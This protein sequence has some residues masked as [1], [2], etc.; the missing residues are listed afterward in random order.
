MMQTFTDLAERANVLWQQR[1]SLAGSDYISLSQLQQHDRQLVQSVGLCQRYLKQDEADLPLWLIALLDNSAAELNKLLALPLALSAQ[2]L[3]AE[4]WL[5]LQQKTAA[6]YMQ[7]YSQPEQSPLLCLLADPQ[8]AASLYPAMQR[9]DLRSA[10]Q[11]AGQQGLTGQ[12]GDLQQLATDHQL[13]A[14]SRA[15][16]LYSLYLLGQRTDESELIVQLLDAQCLTSRQLQLLLLGATTEQKVRI[17]NALCSA[18][19]HL[20]INAMGFSGLTKFCPL[21]LEMTHQPAHSAAAQ[22]ALITMLGALS[23][24]VLQRTEP[25]Q[26]QHQET[27]VAGQVLNQLKLPALWASGNQYQRFAAAALQVLQQP[28]L[29]LAEPM[30]WQ[31]GLWPVA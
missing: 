22:S 16:L 30:N 27:L 24:D 8:L 20:A 18:D 13:S 15:E 26:T 6:H 5:A 3:L 14:A 23:A 4:L 21:L 1:L 10:V 28:G 11:L 31:G 29:P 12:L 19:I 9:L 2:A 7:Q 25:A 17:V